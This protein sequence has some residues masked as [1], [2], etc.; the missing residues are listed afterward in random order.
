MKM[1]LK[2]ERTVNRAY[3]NEL[4]CRKLSSNKIEAKNQARIAYL[5]E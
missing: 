5:E 1:S 2:S 4:E 3:V